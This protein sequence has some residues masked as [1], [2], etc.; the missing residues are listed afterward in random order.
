MKRVIV[1]GPLESSAEYAD[2]ARRVGWEA[3]EWPLLRIVQHRHDVGALLAQRFDW[4]C[5]TSSSALPFLAELCR[6][7]ST[8][9]STP[10]AI[11]G[12][13]SGQR[14]RDLGLRIELVAA[15]SAELCDE[16]PRRA[17]RGACVLWPRGYLSDDVSRDLR[18]CELVVADPVV[19]ATLALEHSRPAPA[20]DAIFFASPSAVRAWTAG[21]HSADARI[22]IAIGHT[23]FDA[24]M[25]ETELAFFD[26]I[27]L[28]EPT[29]DAFAF[30]LAH[31]DIGRAEPTP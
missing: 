11:V 21:E 3:F 10:C 9:R 18:R 2:S 14:A 30:V 7:H 27:S 31:L 23:T 17:S 1:T 29:P 4:I 16:L 25:S 12:A 5:V 19:Y 20:S 6:A 13:R 24:L 8:L 26:T 15:S 22:A 28:P